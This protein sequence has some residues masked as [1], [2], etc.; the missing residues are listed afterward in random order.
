MQKRT[1]CA[2]V[3][4]QGLLLLLLLLLLA[5]GCASTAIKVGD[6]APD[7]QLSSLDGRTV[8][9]SDFRGKPILLSFWAY[10]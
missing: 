3:I 1:A 7:F 4:A 6:R 9:L 5:G 2:V 10:G 8:K